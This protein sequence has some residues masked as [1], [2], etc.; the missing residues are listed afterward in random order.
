MDALLSSLLLYIAQM[1]IDNNWHRSAELGS[2]HYFTQAELR[3]FNERFPMEPYA[4]EEE[5]KGKTV[6]KLRD[7]LERHDLKKSGKKAELIERLTTEMPKL[8]GGYV[9]L[10]KDG[11]T[12]GMIRLYSDG[13]NPK[14]SFWMKDGVLKVDLA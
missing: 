4:T 2:F 10:D 6:E 7:M 1:C 11:G 13:C 5:L 12:E 14:W 8:E 3:D 9:F